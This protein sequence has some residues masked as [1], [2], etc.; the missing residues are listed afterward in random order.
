MC[1]G[2][3]ID[4]LIRMLNFHRSGWQRNA[5]MRTSFISLRISTQLKNEKPFNQATQ[6]N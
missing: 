2:N 5:R 3:L 1:F 4:Y 6:V